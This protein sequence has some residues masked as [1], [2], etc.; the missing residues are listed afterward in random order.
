MADQSLSFSLHQ[1]TARMDV[2]ADRILRSELG[3]SYARFLAVFG[4]G[5]LGS[6]TQ[7]ELAEWLGLSEPSVSRTAPGLKADGY[8]EALSTPGEGNRK[9][10]RLTPSG[11][12]LVQQG[13][14]LLERRFSSIV[15][16]SNVDY[17]AFHDQ[18]RALLANLDPGR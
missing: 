14:R 6:A 9:L 15:Q 16:A 7:R 10:L 2:A 5:V 4:V 18:V 1:L 3:I 17:D 12:S 11:R 13:K 8:V